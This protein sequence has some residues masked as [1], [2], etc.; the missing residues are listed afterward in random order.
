MLF[1]SVTKCLSIPALVL[2]G[3]ILLPACVCV[4]HFSFCIRV[5]AA[6]PPCVSLRFQ[7]S[8]LFSGSRFPYVH[9]SLVLSS[10]RTLE[11]SLINF[12]SF[13]YCQ[14]ALLSAQASRHG[15]GS[16]DQTASLLCGLPDPDTHTISI[17]W[18]SCSRVAQDAVARRYQ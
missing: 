3:E 6:L 1:S 9:A 14:S 18:E 10:P 4:W 15:A 5:R 12:F 17:L 7:V 16:M 11:G 8:R 2:Q 13:L